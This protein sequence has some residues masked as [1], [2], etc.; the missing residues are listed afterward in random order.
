MFF[1]RK[2]TLYWVILVCI[3]HSLRQYEYI[4]TYTFKLVVYLLHLSYSNC[5]LSIFLFLY[6]TFFLLHKSLLISVCFLDWS[7]PFFFIAGVICTILILA[8]LKKPPTYHN[9]VCLYLC[10]YIYICIY[11][12][13]NPPYPTSKDHFF[14]LIEW[15]PLARRIIYTHIIINL[16][17]GNQ[18]N[19]RF[20]RWTYTF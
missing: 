7:I 4:F 19:F 17:V 20:K 15:Y 6:I 16:T 10:V 8:I 13:L 12:Y 3:Y 1:I 9:P 5:N 18:L 11:F 14:F 2:I